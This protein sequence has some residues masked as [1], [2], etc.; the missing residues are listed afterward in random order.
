MQLTR[1][2]V[3]AVKQLARCDE[4]KQIV[5]HC[6][7][8]R[9]TLGILQDAFHENVLSRMLRFLCDSSETHGLGD[10]F[11]RQWLKSI[12]NC[13]FKLGKGAFQID[14][15]FNWL[16]RTQSETNRYI[17][18]VLVIFRRGTPAPIAVFGVETKIDAP[19]SDKQIEDYQRALNQRFQYVRYRALLYLTPDGRA[20]QTGMI[21]SD[22]ECY[23]TS[24]I[25]IISAC[26]LLSSGG[27]QVT[28]TSKQTKA[29]LQDLS[30]FLSR[31]VMKDK[32]RSQIDE[33]LKKL[34]NDPASARALDIVRGLTHRPTIRSFVYEWLLP[35]IRE[36]FGDVEVDWHFP[37]SSTRPHEFNF[38]HND[39][40]AKLPS[41]SRFQIFYM[42]HSTKREPSSGDSVSVLLM[43]YSPKQE[44]KFGAALQ[45]RFS[46]IR[47]E[48]PQSE[49]EL[50]QWGPWLCLWASAEH[51]LNGF[52]ADEADELAQLYKRTVDTTKP[53]LLKL[54]K[55]QQA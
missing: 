8:S 23:N 28:L 7:V 4:F 1:E 55:K 15:H 5:D 25:S 11:V 31:D 43:A 14:A 41:R 6:Q 36:E 46:S 17:D 19:E 27:G 50:R 3:L 9:T 49:G 24:Y 33:L 47:E 30:Q 35:K 40:R 44:R 16:V 2:D 12:P 13:S 52:D 54:L 53:I 10:K 29:L 18:L 39:I 26:E 37:N 20:N 32:R 34:Q 42:L 38:V 48:L 51:R 22:C 45:T 21:D